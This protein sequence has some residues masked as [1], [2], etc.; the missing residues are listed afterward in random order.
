[1]VMVIIKLPGFWRAK[2]TDWRAILNSF[3]SSSKQGLLP[4]QARKLYIGNLQA[5]DAASLTI[6]AGEYVPLFGASF[7][8]I[9]A[10]GYSLHRTQGEGNSYAAPGDHFVRYRLIEPADQPD[11]GFF[12]HV[13]LTLSGLIQRLGVSW[14]LQ[15]SWTKEQAAALE[16]SIQQAQDR[17]SPSDFSAMIEPLIRGLVVLRQIREKIAD[18]ETG[19]LPKD[20]LRFLLADKEQDF[21]RALDLATGLSFEALADDALVTPGQTFAV[22]AAL[23]NRSSIT[24]RP[25][26]IQLQPAG[27]PQGWK[28]ERVGDLPEI[29]KPSERIESKF[30]VFVPPDAS[31]TQP[32]W[33]RNGR[34][35]TMYSVPEQSLINS[36]LPPAVL[37]A[38]LDYSVRVTAGASAGTAPKSGVATTDLDLSKNQAVE[39]LDLDSRKGP[40]RIPILVVPQLAINLTPV[41]QVVPLNS[42]SHARLIQ[43]ELTNNSPSRVE[44]DLTLKPP[45]GWTV[46]PTQQSFSIS[47]ES[48][49]AIF[50]FE[51]KSAGTL[52]P[53]KASF[54]ATARTKGKSFRLGYQIIS[55]MDL[56]KI[57]LYRPA[58]TNVTTLDVQTPSQLSVGYIMGAGDKVPETLSQLGP[59][60]KLLEANDL[61]SGDLS[62]FSCLIAGIRAYDVRR[63]LIA[64]NARLLDYVK[65]GGVYIVQYNTPAAW[66]KA[67][68]APYTAKIQNASHRVTDETAPVAILDADHRVFNFPN[69]ITQKDFDGWVQERGLYFVQERD[70]HFKAL[71]S[72][73]DPGDPPLDG[74][75]LVAP[76]GKGLYVL[77]SYSWF[78]QLPEGVPGAI[79]IFANLI[80]LGVPR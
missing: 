59:K 20:T 52:S 77:T 43:V 32:H 39:F 47:R 46:E 8:Q 66:N 71:L 25:K 19:S 4:W 9:G 61:A 41:A 36:P 53:G 38:K 1:M 75:L 69:K 57:P 70:P 29:L 62:Q 44:G 3:R 76:Y 65:D 30:K 24:I 27:G 68:Y 31:P 55:V 16:T 64:N 2:L 48:E 67:Q 73:H 51:V 28:I 21:T 34:S 37:M 42:S 40:H 10:T 14:N 74:G 35:D 60:V 5:A 22:T 17:F 49:T 6:N 80:S 23:T 13:D 26:Q 45:S 56:W 54:E 63:D 12:D 79:R 7:Q 72:C 15:P 50:P 18:G 58:E 11:A 78:R 33:K